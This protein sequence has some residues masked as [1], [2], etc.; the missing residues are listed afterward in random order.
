VVFVIFVAPKVSVT[1]AAEAFVI[2]V[3]SKG[4]YAEMG[5][6]GGPRPL[7]GVRGVRDG[8]SR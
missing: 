8:V 1:F 3:A 7:Y 6:G 5:N 4:N 2:F